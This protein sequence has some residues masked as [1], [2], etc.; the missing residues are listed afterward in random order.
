[1]SRVAVGPSVTQDRED[2]AS[3]LVRV[4]DDSALVAAAHGERLLVR[5]ELAALGARGGMGALD[6]HGA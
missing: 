6:E 3:E 4:G 2:A 5:L 1:R